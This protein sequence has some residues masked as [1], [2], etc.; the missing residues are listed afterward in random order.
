MKEL[1]GNGACMAGFDRIYD[2]KRNRCVDPAPGYNPSSDARPTGALGFSSCWSQLETLCY[3]CEGGAHRRKRLTIGSPLA[4]SQRGAAPIA[5]RFET[6]R[7]QLHEHL[8][9]L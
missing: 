1:V 8:G 9:S 5:W 2:L 4:V 6:R 7:T 3:S